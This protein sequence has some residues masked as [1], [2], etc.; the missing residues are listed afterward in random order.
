MPAQSAR[1]R[2]IRRVWADHGSEWKG[3][4]PLIIDLPSPM[5]PPKP[6]RPFPP[7]DSLKFEI[8]A[9]TVKGELVN[10][11]ACEG[12]VVKRWKART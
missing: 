7:H 1:E 4:G 6:Y 10:E 9:S 12:V 8:L 11:I 2:L 5:M 3:L